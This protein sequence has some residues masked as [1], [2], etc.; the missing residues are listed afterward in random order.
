MRVLKLDTK[1]VVEVPFLEAC[2]MID[3]R[4]AVEAP[5]EKPA[6]ESAVID[7][8]RQTMTQPRPQPR[9]PAPVREKR[10]KKR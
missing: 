7:R 4:I 9:P 1:E 6:P 5:M 3:A 10:R 8:S 2:E